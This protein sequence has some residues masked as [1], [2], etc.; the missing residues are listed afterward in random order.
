MKSN[1]IAS[2]FATGLL[3]VGCASLPPLD[4]FEMD[5]GKSVKASVT[6]TDPARLGVAVAYQ[7]EEWSRAR[8]ER[9]HAFRLV[10]DGNEVRREFTRDLGKLGLFAGVQEI[11][12]KAIVQDAAPYL[13]EARRKNLDLLLVLEPRRYQVAY[14]GHN[15]MFA[16]NLAL[17][18]L[19][20]FPSWWI[21]DEVFASEVSFR[22]TLFRVDDGRKIHA[23]DWKG[24]F[25]TALDDFQ[26][27]WRF[28]GIFRV[29]ASLDED[30]FRKV[31][32]TL[33]PHAMNLSKIDLMKDLAGFV[34]ERWPAMRSSP[35]GP[36]PEPGNEP[37]EEPEPEPEPGPGTEP[38]APDAPRRLALV[39]G[40]GTFLDADVPP[41]D[42]AAQDASAMA[43]YLEK[44]QRFPSASVKVLTGKQASLSAVKEAL[45][46][47]AQTPGHPEDVRVVY[48]AGRG[49]ARPSGAGARLYLLLHDSRPEN[50][51]RTALA[52]SDLG[53]KLAACPGGKV[54][55]LLDT[56]FSGAN[57]S[58][59][60]GETIP[61]AVETLENLFASRSGCAFVYGAGKNGSALE[62]EEAAG[63]LFTHFFLKGLQG[64]AD[65]DRDKTIRLEELR[66]YLAR[67]VGQ[68]A[69]FLG[70]SQNPVIGNAEGEDQVIP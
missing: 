23:A 65:A 22:G 39:I 34:K 14:R 27:N 21:A 25:E 50:P 49:L 67:Y 59:S 43:S 31:G 28:W 12:E 66:V 54:R 33:S 19:F 10:L 9:G 37:G 7:A 70:K 35:T 8:E 13:A 56:S 26:R 52:L 3:A 51:V 53:E 18:V 61:G 1:L 32:R 36:E 58:R 17:W 45:A 68:T 64:E 29:P 20:W 30:D 16:P 6:E 55:L 2:V 48:F 38:P 4:V 63:G 42:Y 24:T 62:L 57:A 11:G 47:L 5:E 46:T 60:F 41:V 69:D 40:A 15:G 44:Y